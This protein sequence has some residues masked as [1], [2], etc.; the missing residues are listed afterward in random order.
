MSIRTMRAFSLFAACLFAMRLEA[1]ADPVPL[2]IAFT[3]V[4]G[5][6]PGVTVMLLGEPV[7]AVSSVR[8]IDDPKGA[9]RGYEVDVT[10]SENG[11]AR[12]RE[13]PSVA[14]VISEK[15]GS[16]KPAVALELVPE[17]RASSSKIQGYGSFEEFWLSDSKKRGGEH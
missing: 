10:L 14:A 13:Q 9:G 11:A 2:T 7:G 1:A 8:R 5:L 16:E 17:P 3:K 6:R 4:K 12:L 15:S